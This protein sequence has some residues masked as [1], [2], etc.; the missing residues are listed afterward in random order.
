MD[1]KIFL[2]LR[3]IKIEHTVF[4]LPFVFIGISFAILGIRVDSALGLKI[5]FII[6]AAVLA[7][8]SGMTL[9]RIID[10]QLDKENPRTS[11]RELVTGKI[12]LYQAKIIATV[13]S[14]LFVMDAFYLNLLAGLLSPLVLLSFYLYP[15]TKKLPAVSHFILGISIGIIVLAGYVGLRASFPSTW[16]LYGYSLFTALWIASFDIIYQNQDREFDMTKGI[17][18]IPC[19]T[20][21]KIFFP[22]A[23][24]NI[25]ASAIL[26]ASSVGTFNLITNSIASLILMNSLR[27]VY[28]YDADKFFK[29]F[30]LPVPFIILSGLI[31]QLFLA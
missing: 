5:L 18:S 29:K 31:F 26:I 6:I 24:V 16:Y 8:I 28:K 30:Y 4:D 13:S 20:K 25:T 22:I 9:N 10:Y 11:K 23:F 15:K 12:K 7:R 2:F 17:K 21:G 27:Y 3:F 14:I 1:S 19:L